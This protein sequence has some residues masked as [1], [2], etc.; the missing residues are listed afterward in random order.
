MRLVKLLF[1]YWFL[2]AICNLS[3]VISPVKAIVDP[4]NVP[5]N[6]VGVH[7]FQPDEIFNA[8]DLVNSHGGN[9]GYVTIPLR[10]DDLDRP[11]WQRFFITAGQ[12]HLIPIIRLATYIN[13]DTWV[14]PDSYDL[15]DFANFLND[16]PWPTKNRYLVIFNEP[17]HA[18]EWGGSVSPGD[19]ASIL[20]QA[21]DIFKSRSDDFFIL[22]AG[23]DM[24]SPN[25][26][27]SM[28]ALLFYRQMSRLVP[29]WYSAIDGLAVHAYPNPGFLSSPLSPGRFGISSYRY[30]VNLLTSL[31]YS[32]K[33]VFITETGYIGQ[34]DFYKIAFNQ[35]WLDKNI[36]AITPFVLFAGAGNFMPFS[37]TD[38]NHKPKNSYQEIFNLAKISG[39]PLLNPL[40][41]NFIP[42]ESATASSQSP[43]QNE[44]FI[45]KLSHFFFP[46]SPILTVGENSVTVE[47]ADNEPA[48]ERGLSYRKSLSQNSG[49]LFEFPV[50]SVQYFW[51][52]DMNFPLDFIWIN[53]HRVVNLS[54]NIPPPK[55]I[56][57]KPE[58]LS[59]VYPVDNVLE[60]NAGY[61]SRHGVKIGDA[62]V[63][64]SP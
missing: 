40:N 62:V 50:S 36:V 41:Q 30:E 15:V 2:F 59:S 27:T 19:Y 28:D 63:L 54:E 24:S 43:P 56:S 9:W 14:E 38:I 34:N 10:S 11:K 25:S 5:N 12:K 52:K 39:S 1:L 37:L 16:M 60:V 4:L 17:N 29:G 51:M 35:V 46:S 26:P 64:N 49:M 47:I 31:G 20:I 3:F 55:D 42:A 33:P 23:L 18:T 58:T 45:N 44:N 8:S 32:P 22:S 53:N 21:R 7:I 48:R 13:G 6:R 57:D 61:I